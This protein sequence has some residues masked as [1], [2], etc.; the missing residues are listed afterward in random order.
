MIALVSVAGFS[1]A[2]TAR[3]ENSTLAIYHSND[4]IGY[5]TPCG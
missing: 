2:Q 4:L 3:H 5:L 1:V